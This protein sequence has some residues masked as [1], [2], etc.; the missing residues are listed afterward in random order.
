MI[1]S[2]SDSPPRPA[3]SAVLSAAPSGSALTSLRRPRA[4]S[5]DSDGLG[6]HARKKHRSAEATSAGETVD[7]QRTSDS[8]RV[9]GG[10]S[11]DERT[12]DMVNSPIRR[13]RQ[14][15]PP[16]TGSTNGHSG[17]ATN[18]HSNG[19]GN[20]YGDGDVGVGDDANGVSVASTS[21]NGRPL[22]AMEYE[23]DEGF[24]PLWEGS[25]LDRREF[26][27]LAMQ[28]FQ[29]MGYTSVLRY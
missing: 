17:S 9:R 1:A 29:D 24:V 13:D 23:G 12:T 22:D 21:R 18:G 6:E 4:S 16:M 2:N 8:D 11:S 15:L 3:A 14:P 28:A 19:N 20:G 7:P 27:R 25:N 10:P 26:V 5:E